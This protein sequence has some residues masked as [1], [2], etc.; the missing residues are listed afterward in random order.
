[1]IIVPNQ[2]LTFA[3]GDLPWHRDYDFKWREDGFA[4][5][6]KLRAVRRHVFL[7]PLIADFNQDVRLLKAKLKRAGLHRFSPV[8]RWATPQHDLTP[9][10][11]K[12]LL[13]DGE[14]PMVAEVEVWDMSLVMGT[15]SKESQEKKGITS[16][17]AQILPS[18]AAPA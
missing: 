7:Y 3:A 11:K 14:G 18:L 8:V 16:T 10:Q 6:E 15:W 9:S 13:S 17:I 2:P 1:M 12:A 4:S 5:N